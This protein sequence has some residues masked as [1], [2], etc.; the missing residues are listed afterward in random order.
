MVHCLAIRV[1]LLTQF[2][3][4]ING[5]EI[6][7]N[8]LLNAINSNDEDNVKKVLENTSRK[9]LN[10]KGNGGQTPLMFA[11]MS[12]KEKVILPLLEAGAL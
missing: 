6:N 8:R 3:I 1:L 11:T 12:R 5:N 2:V 9:Q 4:F 7:N 10:K